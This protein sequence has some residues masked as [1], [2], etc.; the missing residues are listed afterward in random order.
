MNVGHLEWNTEEIAEVLF[1]FLNDAQN[2]EDFIVSS[3]N[4]YHSYANPLY[5][6]EFVSSVFS[7]N[8][9]ERIHDLLYAKR[10]VINIWREPYW[11]QQPGY[12]DRLVEIISKS[13]QLETVYINYCD[14]DGVMLKQVLA[15][16]HASIKTM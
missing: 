15:A 16:L 1:P 11:M 7:S 4:I 10:K 5:S 13:T 2:L 3:P 9:K 14:L 6:P 12:F 8:N